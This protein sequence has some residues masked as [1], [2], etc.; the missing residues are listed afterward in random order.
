[1]K[2]KIKAYYFIQ[3]GLITILAFVVFETLR[4]L[5]YSQTW[6]E[7]GKSGIVL[8]V[9][10]AIVFGLLNM[11]I[12]SAIFV[13]LRRNKA[14]IAFDL[15]SIIWVI[16]GI[17]YLIGIQNGGAKSF[18]EYLPIVVFIEPIIFNQG[19]KHLLINR[20]TRGLQDPANIPA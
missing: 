12:N 19:I 15:P 8:S 10:T 9:F 7:L 1:M 20:N 18:L 2:L 17:A 3:T 14:R 11:I 16:I 6:S 5:P 4:S 13:L